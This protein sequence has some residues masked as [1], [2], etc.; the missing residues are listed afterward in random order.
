MSLVTVYA[1]T[2]MC[3]TEE[4]FYAKFD[5]VLDQCSRRDALIVLDVFNLTL[6]L[7]LGGIITRLVLALL[8]LVP[9][10]TTA[11]SFLLHLERSRGLRIVGS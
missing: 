9:G 5:S 2:Q 7:A 4:M 11:L 8:A 10:T 6:S 3:G 1:P